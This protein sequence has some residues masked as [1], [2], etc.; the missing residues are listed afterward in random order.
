MAASGLHLGR[1]APGKTGDAPVDSF[2]ICLDC[3]ADIDSWRERL[4]PIKTG[5]LAITER[6]ELALQVEHDGLCD[7]CGG[8]RAEIRVEARPQLWS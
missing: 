7:R 6:G 3:G 5:T 2:A 4:L 8:G 1:T